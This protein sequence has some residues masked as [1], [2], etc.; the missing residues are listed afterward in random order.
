MN[1]KLFWTVFFAL[2]SA[3]VCLY[4]LIRWHISE[5]QRLLT[6]S[7]SEPRGIGFSAAMSQDIPAPA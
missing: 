1:S 4:V 2:V 6:L 5:E 7:M 3:G